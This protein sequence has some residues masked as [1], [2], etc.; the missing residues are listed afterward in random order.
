M[1]SVED[2]A[3]T[4]FCGHALEVLRR[5]PSES[6]HMAMTSPPYWGLR[7]YRTQEIVWDGDPLCDHDFSIETEAGD[8][9]YRGAETSSVTFH[10]DPDASEGSGKGYICSICGAWLGELG[11]EPKP[12]LYIKH[13]CDIFDEV[14]RVLKTYGSLWVNISDTYSSTRWSTSPSTTGISKKCSDVV[15]EKDTN[16]P[17]KS[18]VGIPERFVIEMTRRGW[19]RRNTVI[20]VKPNCMPES[21][22]DRFTRDFEYIYFFTKNTDTLYWTNEKNLRL[23]MRQPKIYVEGMDWEWRPCQRCLGTGFITEGNN[24]DRSQRTLESFLKENEAGIEDAGQKTACRKCSGAGRIRYSLWTGHDYYFEQQFEPYK[25]N[26]WGGRYKTNEDVKTSPRE[27]QCGGQGSLNRMGYD[28][29]P[30]P[31]GRNMRCV[32]N[33]KTTS[34]KG[35][36]FAVYPEELCTTPIRAGCPE[37]VCKNC[38]MPRVKITKPAI[39]FGRS[40]SN[41]KYIKSTQTAGRLAEKRQAYRSLGYESPPMPILVGYSD[42]GCNGYEPG[43]VLDPFL[44]SGTTALAALKLNRSFVGIDSNPEYVEMAYGRIRP[45]MEQKKIVELFACEASN[46]KRL[47]LLGAKRPAAQISLF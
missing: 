25:I 43:I 39:D 42:C 21:P 33:I 37:H 17:G 24:V 47:T 3:N 35:A 29:Y 34:F 4:I 22:D 5:F 20:W 30:N 7:S 8:I 10:K 28:C 45:Y 31:F 18:L 23:V 46:T 36:H 44:G 40:I 14:R 11:H 38:G 9:R 15:I 16:M 6:V 27:K 2:I 41:T 19:I 1:Y 26:R 32:W 13:L 12:D